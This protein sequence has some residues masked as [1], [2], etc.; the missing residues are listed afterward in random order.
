MFVPGASGSSAGSQHETGGSLPGQGGDLAPRG[1]E[2]PLHGHAL[3]SAGP[4]GA[5]GGTTG[6]GSETRF[7]ALLQIV[8]KVRDEKIR[9]RYTN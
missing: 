8:W 2:G 9:K 6:E 1:P 7:D 4:L 3:A 5:T